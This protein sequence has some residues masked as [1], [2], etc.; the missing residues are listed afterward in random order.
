MGL[1]E[2]IIMSIGLA[3][4]AFSVSICKGLSIKKYKI[5]NSIIIGLYFGLFHMLMP[6]IGYFLGYSFERFITSIDHWIAFILLSLIG[7]HMIKESC[8]KG[9][10]K[11]DASIKFNSMFPLA[12]AT[13]IDCLAVGITMAFLRVNIYLSS[14]IIGITTFIF[15]VIGVKIGNA[16]GRKYEKNAQLFGGI[17]LIIIGFKIL[18]EHLS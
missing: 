12:L 2:I 4:D 16:F 18:I 9:K 10:K 11:E 3:M 1:L 7:F 5:K 13:S 17:I 8:S 15:S 6:I 14:I